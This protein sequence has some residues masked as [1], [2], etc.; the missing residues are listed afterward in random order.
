MKLFFIKCVGILLLAFTASSA[1]AAPEIQPLLRGS[2]QKIIEAH[3]GKPFIV[4]LWSVSCTHCG[5]DLEIF[6]RLS[7]K[8]S[9][10]NLVLVSTDSPDQKSVIVRTLKHYN[11]IRANKPKLARIESWVFAESYTE[12]LRFEIDAQWYGELPRTYFFDAQGK[13]TAISGVLDEAETERWVRD[14]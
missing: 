13:A 5:A 4:A 10:F 11:L 12:R 7:K 9:D 14:S 1:L 2:F 6:N 3:A 8:Y